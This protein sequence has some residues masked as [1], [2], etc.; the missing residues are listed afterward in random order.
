MGGVFC[1]EFGVS[2]DFFLRRVEQSMYTFFDFTL[3]DV[4]GQFFQAGFHTPCA[5]HGPKWT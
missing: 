5:C 3:N 4:H 1:L 2:T